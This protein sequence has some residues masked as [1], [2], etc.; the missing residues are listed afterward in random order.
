MEMTSPVA[1]L[2]SEAIR[3]LKRIE[4]ERLAAEGFFDDEKVELLFGVVVKMTPPDPSHVESTYQLRRLIEAGLHD[5]ARVMSQS[6]LAASDD[7][8]P[9]PDVFVVP[10]A[11]YWRAHPAKALLV[12]EVSRSSLRLDRG[13]KALLYEFCEVDEYWIVDVEGGAVEVYRDAHEGAWQTKS[14]HH[15]GETIA[16]RAFPDVQLAVSEI[17]PPLTA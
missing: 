13:V 14:T 1:M 17:L 9:E 3:P 16:M 11:D 10:N 15:R 5:R 2:A 12:V 4:Y 6:P 7:S 8:M